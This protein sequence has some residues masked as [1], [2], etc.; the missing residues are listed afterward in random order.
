MIAIFFAL[1]NEITS[2]KRSLNTLED[3][4]IENTQ[5]YKVTVDETPVLLVQTGMGIKNSKS[6]VDITVENFEIDTIISTGFTGG[7]EDGLE[8]GDLLYANSVLYANDVKESKEHKLFVDKKVQ[9]CN[10]YEAVIKTVCDD[11]QLMV[12]FGNAITVN[13]IIYNS[14]HKKW[15]GINSAAKVVDMETFAIAETAAAKRIPFISVR[16]VS[17]DVNSDLN[18]EKFGDIMDGGE[19]NIKK[20]GLAVAKNLSSIPDLLKLRK[21]AIVASSSISKFLSSFVRKV[22]ESNLSSS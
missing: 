18:L 17:D 20:T 19:V 7:L 6:A 10:D 11:L 8:V 13:S 9:C 4:K 22:L 2:F 3:F 5:F 1:K 16:A 14:S 12:H 21:Q 15:L